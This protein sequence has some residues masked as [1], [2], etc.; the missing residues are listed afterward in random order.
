MCPLF[1]A[2][3]SYKVSRS[4]TG[5]ARMSRIQLE[6]GEPP[7]VMVFSHKVRWLQKTSCIRQC[8]GTVGKTTDVSLQS[9]FSYTVT[10]ES[11][12]S[13]SLLYLLW[14]SYWTRHQTL[15]IC[16]SRCAKILFHGLTFSFPKKPR[17]SSL[18][19]VRCVTYTYFKSWT[20][21]WRNS[22]PL[23]LNRLF[24]DFPHLDLGPLFA[25]QGPVAAVG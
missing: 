6:L 4:I 1:P 11:T 25:L 16:D 3:Q 10:A 14:T 22:L 9:L 7:H 12:L 24:F 8:T 19:Q 15:R 20:D 13:L 2:G 5:S 18:S 21:V 17:R 23:A